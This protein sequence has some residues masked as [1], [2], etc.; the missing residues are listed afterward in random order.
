MP[1]NMSVY[2]EHM[3]ASLQCICCHCRMWERRSKITAH[4]NIICIIKPFTR[5]SRYVH[6]YIGFVI[7]LCCNELSII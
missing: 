7:W 4:G 6:L 3:L 2:S 1:I 5:L